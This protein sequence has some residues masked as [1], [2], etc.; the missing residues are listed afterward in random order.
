MGAL[1][2]T[3]AN[4]YTGI[5]LINAGNIAI[6]DGNQ[7]GT[8][9]YVNMNGGTLSA[10]EAS[11]TLNK[12]LNFLATSN[13]DVAEGRILTQD[14]SSIWQGAGSSAENRFGHL[15]PAGRQQ[16]C[17]P[18]HHERCGER[19][20][21]TTSSATLR[22]PGPLSSI[23]ASA[24]YGTGGTP[25]LRFTENIANLNRV[26]T[27]S[28]TGAIEVAANKTV[29]STVAA[30]GT[31]VLHKVG[32]GTLQLT[33][34]N[35]AATPWSANA[36]V[37]EVL[38]TAGAAPL[39]TNSTTTLNGGT[40]RITN[41]GVADYA[42]GNTGTLNINGGGIFDINNSVAFNDQFTFG[43]IQRTNQGT[44][45]IQP[46]ANL[47]ATAGQRAR[48]LATTQLLGV[49]VASSNFNGIVSPV[50]VRLADGAPNSDA[51]F[52]T[53]N[54]TNGF[55]TGAPTTPVT[56]LSALAPTAVGNITTPQ[57][58][59]GTNSI[60][61]FKTTANVSGGVLR[62]VA[63][64][65]T[66]NQVQL[67]GILIN[68]AGGA[69]PVISSDLF[70]GFVNN[71]ATQ[72]N[73][74]NY[75]E[76]VVY[77]STGFT[78]GT[79]TLSGSVVANSFTK[80]GP[81]T[82]LFSGSNRISGGLAVQ[83]GAVQFSGATAQPAS[84]NIVLNDAGTLDLNGT[85][86]KVGAPHRIGG[87]HHQY[88]CHGGNAHRRGDQQLGLQRNHP[89]WRRHGPRHQGRHRHLAAQRQP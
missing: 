46:T 13:V 4:T 61:A 15:G 43:N 16:L 20:C 18:D 54:T 80:F 14:G 58:L 51:D 74:L 24:N 70:F 19:L 1:R 27:M 30:A 86:V 64:G 88:Q 65:S 83:S 53:Y 73:G 85:N 36:G 25:M 75:G 26:I 29:T 9:P 21:A 44:M 67:G 23:N 50:I 6:T 41:A 8:N 12:N 34:T 22:R 45:V 77:T 60:Y 38:Q 37:I 76:G 56:T 66:G 48:L 47:G 33:V 3:N 79:P 82:L 5:T 10:W 31:G 71:G 17:G 32:A 55:L 72:L 52:V 40:I 57:V 87:H 28:T 78:S 81:G 69:A 59:T 35:A 63:N 68:G 62:I 42:T 39:G 89:G 7:L 11:F 49:A 2:L 84:H